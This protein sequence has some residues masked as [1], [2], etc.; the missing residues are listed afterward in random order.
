VRAVDQGTLDM[1]AQ[2]F[3]SDARSMSQS[4]AAVMLALRGDLPGAEAKLKAAEASKGTDAKSAAYVDLAA[5]AIAYAR[6]ELPTAAERRYRT[7]SAAMQSS[8]DVLADPGRPG[9]ERAFC[10][11]R[12]ASSRR[13]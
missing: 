8:C 7:P 9:V 13:I 12:A 10:T 5:S 2:V 11:T 3:V 4:S 1:A 6:G